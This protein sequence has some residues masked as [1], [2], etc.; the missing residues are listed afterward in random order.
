MTFLKY[1]AT[2][3]KK[4]CSFISPSCL[5]VIKSLHILRR[6]RYV[7]RATRHKFV[8]SSTTP[9]V[10]GVRC[11]TSVLRRHQ[12][13]RHAELINLRPL[14]SV[15]STAPPVATFTNQ[16]A[17]FMLLNTRSL[18]NKAGLIHDIIIDKKLEFMC[19][20]ETWQA[21]QDFLSLNHATPP[22]YVYIQK[23]R[24]QGR[25]GGL[26]VIYRSDILVKEL[27]TN[28]A[29]FE[30]VHFVL[31][32]AAQLQVV[33]VYRPPKASNTFLSEFSELLTAV[34]P[35]SPY[36]II[37]G[38]FN[39]HVDSSSCPFAA[40]FLSL[41]DCFNVSQHVQG[42]THVKGHTLDLV[43]TFGLTPVH[44]E[45]LDLAVSDHHAVQF[46]V[47]MT[48]PKH[49]AKRT[50]TFRNIR[51]VSTPTLSN[52]L[53]THFASNPTC[54][55][56]DGLVEHYNTALSLSL[57]AVA[58]L[59]TRSIS[60]TQPAPWF[61]PELRLMKAAGRRLERLQKKSGL[62]VHHEIFKDHVRDY[63]KALSQAKTSY[64][65][66]LINNQQN[67]PKRLFLTIN[68]LLRPLDAPQPSDAAELCS[69]FSR[70][71]QEKVDTIYQQLHQT[72]IPSIPAHQL[73]DNNSTASV[74]PPQCSLSSFAALE[75]NQVMDL[76]SKA[77]ST[78]CKLDPMPTTLVKACLPTLCPAMASIINISLA[79]GVVPTSFKTAVVIPTLKKPGLDPDDPSNHR[80]ISNLPFLSKILERAVA[81]QLQ[82]HMSHH[83]LCEPFQSG[84]RPHHSTETALIK[85]M[86]DLFTAADNGL[87]SLLILLDLSAAFDTVS[88]AILLN[89]LHEYLGL[90]DSALSW[91]QSYLSGRKQ[92]ITIKDS[93]S[94]PAPVNH[95]VPQGSVLGPLLFTIYMLPL[96]QIIRHH[97]LS[98]HCYADD[99]QLY[100]STKPSA[101][102]PP[103]S[104]VDCLHKIKTWMTANLLKL[105]NKKTE[106]LVVAPPSLAKK[107]GDLFLVVDGDTIRPSPEVRNLGVI[108]DPILSLQA[109]IK[110]TTKSAFFH[111]KNISRLRPSLSDSVTE[112][113]I[114]AFITSRLDYCNGVLYGLP[115]KTLD[116]LQ[117]VQNSAARVLTRSK[118]W[119]HITPTLKKLHWL[120][121]KFRISYK[122]LLLTYKSLHGL[123]P[124]YLADLLH[125]CSQPRSLRSSDKDQL[126]TP[127]TRLR[128]FGD[129]A[130]CVSAPT[131]WNKLPLH[132]RHAPTLLSFKK[133]LKAY[134][135][136]EAFGL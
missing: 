83:E 74:H 119:Q 128:T 80:P 5:D 23:P 82:Q 136:T 66:T 78:F 63:K 109:H 51:R 24:C 50:I 70:F 59:K 98:F 113:L 91:F 29:T 130:F 19:L 88:H 53:A 48:Q 90:T 126:A 110:T 123:A 84:F 79:L 58:P 129:R 57:D 105:N 13:N 45:C 16:I 31:A 46:S 43:C 131:L 6:P 127:R 115:S 104:L 25:G 124:Q 122:I 100:I 133:N 52:M 20:T 112:T 71:F 69:E 111:L 11:H 18:N 99:T 72:G 15:D 27:P 116:R 55:T 114:H 54:H 33:L 87:I 102:L 7:H 121:V 132:I 86:N 120:P 61:T 12:S 95:G 134:L 34:C 26:A 106:L 62:V 4:L 117:Y 64:Y 37:M 32:G 36:T 96:G 94:T 60:F 42:P 2:E 28:S 77:K 22:G 49:R 135:F 41:L 47:P 108:L 10:S 30:Y 68:R 67:H 17:T 9:A 97:G 21:Q 40:E 76:V 65:S 125:R 89:R 118:P 39:I 73:L 38:D 103:I 1:S 56:A 85:I 93:N 81:V 8:H 101:Q 92:Y 107:V 35:M 75:H 14:A 3:L 44:L